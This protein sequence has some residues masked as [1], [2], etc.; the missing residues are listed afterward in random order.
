MA[1]AGDFP[2]GEEPVAPLRDADLHHYPFH[3]KAG[4]VQRSISQQKD[5]LHFD[6]NGPLRNK[7]MRGRRM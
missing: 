3:F 1:V 4:P 6:I 7:I 2:R 5:F